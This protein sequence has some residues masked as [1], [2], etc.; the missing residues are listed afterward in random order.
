MLYEPAFLQHLETI[1][2]R[3]LPVWNL[4][5]DAS[6]RQL[7]ISE[8]AT[9]LA[10]SPGS[11]E[12]LVMRVQ[13]PGYHTLNEIASE[14]EWVAAL[15]ASGLVRTAALQRTIDGQLMHLIDD[16]E[17]QYCV[18]AFEFVDGHEPNQEDDLI[19]WYRQLGAITARLHEHSR[20]WQRPD[21]FV[22]KTWNY[23]TI[24]G[25]APHWGDWRKAAGLNADDRAVLEDVVQALRPVLDSYDPAGEKFGLIHCDMRASNLLVGSDALCVV[26]FDDCGLSWFFYD[27][28]ACVSFIE[29]DPRLPDYLAA[30]VEGYRTVG[31]I[32]DEDLAILPAF[33]MLRRLQLTA[34]VAGHSETPTAQW[35]GTEVYPRGTAE[36]ARRFLTDP[37]LILNPAT[38]TPQFQSSEVSA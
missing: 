15:R 12:R 38:P 13:R 34:W 3:A 16:G 36:M 19:Y 8:N 31:T 14:L 33:I 1:L 11:G 6:V 7:T 25:P 37:A 26:D 5:A 32:T 35:A 22:R 4:P 29:L 21:G 18:T 24:L 2:T 23:D 30:W 9:F 27:F 17:Q 20:S 10:Q 28:A